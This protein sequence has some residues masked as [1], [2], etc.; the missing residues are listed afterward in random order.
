MIHVTA[1]QRERPA[2]RFRLTAFGL[3][4][5]CDWPLTGSVPIAADAQAPAPATRISRLAGDDFTA[6]WTA[7]SERIF[8]PTSTAEGRGS[9]SIA[10]S[11]TT[12]CGWRTTAAT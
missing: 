4:A 11:S 10:A 9:R 8:E 7:P 2:G 1:P 12:R 5:E 3:D 6:A